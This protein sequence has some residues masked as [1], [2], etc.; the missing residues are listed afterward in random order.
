MEPTTIIRDRDFLL[1]EIE[2]QKKG[3]N[4]AEAAAGRWGMTTFLL[5]MFLGVLVM[6][7]ALKPDK[8]WEIDITSKRPEAV[9]YFQFWSQ[10][11][12]TRYTWATNS[13]GETGWLPV[14]GNEIAKDA[15]PLGSDF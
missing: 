12:Q 9:F 4:I 7:W 3:R 6:G 2:H 14:D 13:D 1:Q 8:S 15:S 5:G 11:R 10:S